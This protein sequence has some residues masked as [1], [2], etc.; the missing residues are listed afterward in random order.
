MRLFFFKLMILERILIFFFNITMNWKHIWFFILMILFIFSFLNIF[1]KFSFIVI[2]NF[3]LNNRTMNVFS[4]IWLP[5]IKRFILIK[6]IHFFFIY[7]K[8]FIFFL[9]V[10]RNKSH[11]QFLIHILILFIFSFFNFKR[12]ILLKFFVIIA[13][14]I[15]F[16]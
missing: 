9:I 2:E 3:L 14:I 4:W 13:G 15:I 16:I 5:F 8:I 6:I 11:I 7:E 12:F 1:N 10:T